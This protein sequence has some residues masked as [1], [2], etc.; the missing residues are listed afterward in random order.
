MLIEDSDDTTDP[1][2]DNFL[3]SEHYKWA[4]DEL[5]IKHNFARVIILEGVTPWMLL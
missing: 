3:I 5:F 2:P 1:C 4:L